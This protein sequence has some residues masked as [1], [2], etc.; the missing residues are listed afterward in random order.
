MIPAF[1]AV[2]FFVVGMVFGILMGMA[3]MWVKAIREEKPVSLVAP[4]ENK[5][6]SVHPNQQLTPEQKIAQDAILRGAFKALG[7]HGGTVFPP[8]HE[9]EKI[10]VATIEHYSDTFDTWKH[11]LE[12]VKCSEWVKGYARNKMAKLSNLV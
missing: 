3:I 5:G 11:I 2:V 9:D 7:S 8:L 12:E 1:L 4:L 10:S 6:K